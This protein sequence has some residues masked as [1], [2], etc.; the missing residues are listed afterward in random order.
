[1]TDKAKHAQAK[2]LDT[3][4]E[5]WPDAD[6]IVFDTSDR[7]TKGYA[8]IP[9]VV[10]LVARLINDVGGH[11]NAGPLYQVL[12]AHDWGQGIV[13]DVHVKTLLYEAGYPGKGDRLERTW[14]ERIKILEK[15]GFIK[16]AKKGFDDYGFILLV[17]PYLAAL[18]L[19]N[20]NPNDEQIKAWRETFRHFCRDFGID[21]KKY[22]AKIKALEEPEVPA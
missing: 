3:R 2:R 19:V 1:M 10:P 4:K 5:L 8:Q 20:A 13:M 22:E 7:S 18:K 6:P 16:T 17:D 9:R 21:L 15:Y 11:E 14:K 12:W